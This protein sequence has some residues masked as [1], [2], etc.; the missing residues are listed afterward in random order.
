MK[1]LPLPTV[2][3]T[4]LFDGPRPRMP[5]FELCRIH[6]PGEDATHTYR[7]RHPDTHADT[8]LADQIYE[9]RLYTFEK[10]LS[11]MK[12]GKQV[13]MEAAPSP[14]GSPSYVVTLTDKGRDLHT[15]K[16]AY[17]IHPAHEGAPPKNELLDGC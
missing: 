5:L 12:K 16:D 17:A 6:I 13:E 3:R 10:A 7:R 1:R 4:A 2:I 9:G 11:G 15:R 14:L 8:P